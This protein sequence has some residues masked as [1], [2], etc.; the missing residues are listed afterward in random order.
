MGTISNLVSGDHRGAVGPASQP[1]RADCYKYFHCLRSDWD[2]TVKCLH[3]K[4]VAV[5]AW[6][7]LLALAGPDPHQALTGCCF[8]CWSLWLSLALPGSPD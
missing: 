5:S 8:V 4:S 6:L 3:E 7:L 2:L 1:V